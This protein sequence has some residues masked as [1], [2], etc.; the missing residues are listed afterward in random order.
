MDPA[1]VSPVCP[2]CHVS[3]R[4][5]DYFCYNCGKN[6]HPVPPSTTPGTILK[7]ML[8]SIFLAPM[9][10]IWGFRYI[11]QKDVRSKIVGFAAMALS[12]LTLVILVQYTVSTINTVQSQVNKQLENFQ[13][14]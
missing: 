9:G 11:P 8:G 5:A 12:I 10:I 7:I 4:P 2:V 3:V 13:G 14:M 6:L 1:S